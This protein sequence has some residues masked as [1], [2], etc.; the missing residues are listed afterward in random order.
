MVGSYVISH[1]PSSNMIFSLFAHFVN[2]S[3]I[4]SNMRQLTCWIKCWID[5]LPPLEIQNEQLLIGLFK[6]RMDQLLIIK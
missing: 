5:L 1:T 3:N 2:Q 6:Y 4:S